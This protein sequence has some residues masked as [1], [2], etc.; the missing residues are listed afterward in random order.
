MEIIERAVP[1][2]RPCRV[3][4]GMVWYVV[5]LPVQ[6][7]KCSVELWFRLNQFPQ[8]DEKWRSGN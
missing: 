1:L 3:L 7:V 5:F 4:Q 2:I 8:S 6:L